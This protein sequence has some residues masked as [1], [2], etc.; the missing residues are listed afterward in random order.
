MESNNY[1]EEDNL[2]LWNKSSPNSRLYNIKKILEDYKADKMEIYWRKTKLLRLISYSRYKEFQEE[3]WMDVWACDG[4]LWNSTLDRLNLYLRSI[5]GT[6]SVITKIKDKISGNLSDDSHKS[7]PQWTEI[8]PNSKL[9]EIKK[10]LECSRSDKLSTIYRKRKLKQFLDDK[11]YKEFQVEIWMSA[12]NCDWKLWNLTLKCLNYYLHIKSKDIDERVQFCW[13]SIQDIQSYKLLRDKET[14]KY[15]CSKT[16]RM[17]WRNFWLIL[18]RWNAYTAWRYPWGHSLLSL[19][20]SKKYEQPN[21]D[22]RGIDESELQNVESEANFMD[23]Y[24]YSLSKFGHRAIWFRDSSWEWYILDPY[25]KVRW[26]RDIYPKKLKD[27][28]KKRKIV[29]AHFYHSNWYKKVI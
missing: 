28:L 18:P 4:K 21:A 16:A 2:D 17:N 5:D 3:I 6:S 25:I 14:W 19:P 10:M 23:F 9:F 13:T 11:E 20:S 8:S 22:W 15:C 24:A 26:E 29:K 27:Y 7:V 12:R 1:R